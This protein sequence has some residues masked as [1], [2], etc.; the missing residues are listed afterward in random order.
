MAGVW[1]KLLRI[2]RPWLYGGI[3]LFAT[4]GAY[5]LNNNLVDLLILWIIGLLGFGMRV[6]D[7]RTGWVQ[8]DATFLRRT[9]R[10]TQDLA[11]EVAALA[12]GL[13]A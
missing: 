12:A 3:L 2:P 11:A 9:S 1:V 4:L 8:G 10:G 5:S 6:L 7:V 13:L